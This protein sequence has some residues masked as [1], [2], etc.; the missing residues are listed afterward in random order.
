MGIDIDK[1]RKKQSAEEQDKKNVGKFN[2]L[3]GS[4][5]KSSLPNINVVER[6]ALSRII[7]QD[8]QVRKFITAIYKQKLFPS[9][10]SVLLLIGNSGTGKT[11]TIKQ[12]L[13][14][15]KM[16]YTIEDATRFTKEG[17]QGSSVEEIIFNLISA[18]NGDIEAAQNGVIVI[19]EIDKKSGNDNSDVGG[20]AVLK[21]L[22]KMVDGEKMK[23][24]I[25]DE[26]EDFILEFDTSKVIFIFA[27]AFSGMDKIIE[28]RND[29]KIG[30]DMLMNESMAD[31]TITKSDLVKYGLT[32]E[33]TGR[34]TTVVQMNALTEQ[35]LYD[36]LKTS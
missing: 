13:S 24:H 30:F 22:L 29:R 25:Q 33:F 1:T 11:E 6:Y 12:V 10:R 21:S 4:L 5:S 15:L 26:F 16:P 17:Y 19:D 34:I 14:K 28:K 31:K 8:E 35:N 27:G 32:E 23:I 9:L 36:I 18:A 7:G 2:S 3:A 20:N